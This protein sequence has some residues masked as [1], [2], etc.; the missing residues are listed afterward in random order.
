MRPISVGT[1]AIIDMGGVD[2]QGVDDVWEQG[3]DSGD[4]NVE[5]DRDTRCRK[6]KLYNVSCPAWLSWFS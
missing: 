5:L 1:K 4:P 2:V 3:S 6:E